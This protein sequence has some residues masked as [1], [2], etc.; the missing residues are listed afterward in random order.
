MAIVKEVSSI[1]SIAMPVL[2]RWHVRR[3]RYAPE[4]ATGGRICLAT[5]IHGDEMLGQLIVFGVAQRITDQPECLHGTVDIYPM[6]NP[7]GLDIGERMTP[8]MNHLDMNR[9]FPGTPDGTALE[10]MCHAIYTDMLGADLVLDIHAST[11][12]KSELYE[13]RLDSR[14]AARMIP[15]CRALNPDVIWV[16]ADKSAYSATLSASLCAAGTPALVLEVD[17][18]RR[19]PQSVADRVVG[20][21]FCKMTEMGLWTGSCA[22]MPAADAVIPCIRSGENIARIACETPGVYVPEDCMGKWL[23]AGDPL[24]T[25]IDALEGVVRETI[26][27]PAGGL[28]FSQR[29]YSAVY[30]GT[31]IARL[32]IPGK[33]GD[34]A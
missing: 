32:Y 24:G 18:R 4:G 7:M 33:D 12:G 23:K 21:I 31:L 30:P 10:A 15:H 13:A 26:T 3:C 14:S 19:H 34:K 5:G 27:A 8:M 29:S 22:P 1:A 11:K 17:E 2:E 9:A 25:V 6:L 28:V 20:S 16:Y